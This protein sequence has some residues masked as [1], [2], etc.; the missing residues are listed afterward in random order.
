MRTLITGIVVASVGLTLASQNAPQG[1]PSPA[2]TQQP[3]EIRLP[4]SGP[5][6]P[7]PAPPPAPGGNPSHDQRTTGTAAEI[8][9]ARFHTP[10]QR[11]G[12]GRRC[13]NSRS[14]S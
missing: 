13:Q 14:G 12:N 7:P 2:P 10:H 3:A 11:S 4:I 8:R 9:G 5:P 1:N 6:R